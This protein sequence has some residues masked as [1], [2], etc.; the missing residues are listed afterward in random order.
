MEIPQ[1]GGEGMIVTHGGRFGGYGLYLLK[2]KP[3]F[4]Y[5]LFDL[6]RFRWEGQTALGAGKHTIT[7]D[8]TYDGPGPGKGGTGILKVD[9]TEVASQK[10]SHTIPFLIT[11]DETFDIGTDTRTPV[12]DHDYQVPFVFTGKISQVRCKL[13]PVQLTENDRKMM[14]ASLVRAKD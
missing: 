2:G 4:V 11:I 13:G 5:N 12:D 7:F 8:F 3:V 14:H 6:E 9:E 1:G 10:I